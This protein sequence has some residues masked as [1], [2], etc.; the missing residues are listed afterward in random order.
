M[1]HST[2]QAIIFNATESFWD[3]QSQVKPSHSAHIKT[4][5]L[6]RTVLG[7]CLKT[8]S[9]VL[10]K[11]IGEQ[12]LQ[13]PGMNVHPCAHFTNKQLLSGL[14]LRSLVGCSWIDSNGS[15]GFNCMYIVRNTYPW[16]S[17]MLISPYVLPLKKEKLSFHLI[18]P[19][20]KNFWW[21]S[22]AG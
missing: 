3:Q 18:T 4:R 21:G 15:W 13:R 22:A 2:S 11:K 7:G 6:N 5:E 12:K 20:K 8:L 9:F 10:C 1:L 17:T 16:K 14:S 19:L